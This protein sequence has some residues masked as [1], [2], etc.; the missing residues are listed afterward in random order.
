MTGVGACSATGDG[1]VMQRF[2]PAFYCVT[3]MEEGLGPQAAAEKAL[4]RI[5]KYYPDFSGGIVAL[6][7][8]GSFGAGCHGMRNFPF[9]YKRDDMEAAAIDYVDCVSL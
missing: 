9:S 5:A 4:L 7:A 6:K 1:D 2:S 3:L 8:D